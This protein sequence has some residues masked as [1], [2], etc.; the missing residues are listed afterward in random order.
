MK[1]AILNLIYSFYFE[2]ICHIFV[3]IFPAPRMFL[4]FI[5]FKLNKTEIRGKSKTFD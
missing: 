4:Y 1:L 2:Y 5:F 3:Y